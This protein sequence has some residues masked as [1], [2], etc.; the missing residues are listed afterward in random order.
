MTSLKL[1]IRLARGCNDG[2]LTQIRDMIREKGLRPPGRSGLVFIIPADGADVVIDT[3]VRRIN[4]ST[5]LIE[6]L[7]ALS[8]VE[9]ATATAPG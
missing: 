4:A 5:E 9:I 7:R 1:E 2:D 8:I 6:S 3:Q